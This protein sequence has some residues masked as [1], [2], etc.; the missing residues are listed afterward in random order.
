MIRLLESTRTESTIS[1]DALDSV[2]DAAS[3]RICG[4]ITDFKMHIDRKKRP[5]AFFKIE[6][7]IGNIEGLAF[8]D[9]YEKYRSDSCEMFTG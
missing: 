3:V 5:M 9:A 4:L 7:F 2:Q 1:L 6:D 8:A